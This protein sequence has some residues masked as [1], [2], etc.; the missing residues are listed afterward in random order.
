MA[1]VQL[2]IALPKPE[3]TPL[4]EGANYFHFSWRGTEVQ[5]LVGY[6]DPLKTLPVASGGLLPVP[7]TKGT[8]I[9]PEITHRIL[10]SVSGFATLKA[11]V[12]QIAAS[13]KSSGVEFE[14]S[15][16]VQ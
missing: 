5:M 10:L 9:S 1:N 11:Q 14:P 7:P 12:D 6:I 13:M 8:Q 16:G 2:K 3:D 4:P 15:V